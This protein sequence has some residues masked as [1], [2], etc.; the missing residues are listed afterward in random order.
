MSPS[1][2]S[3][4]PFLTKYLARCHAGELTYV[5]GTQGQSNIAFRD[6]GDLILEQVTTDVWG[7]F[8]RSFDPNPT[9]QYLE[10]RGYTNT[11][12]VLKKSGEWA[13]ITTENRTPLR[14]IDMPHWSSVPFRE[15]E[16]C[17]VLGLPLAMLE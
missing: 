1:A 10:A 9:V 4:S 16:Q 17:A 15:V 2:G 8:A 6:P 7:A 14:L 11:T 13:P 12:A 5:F 3:T